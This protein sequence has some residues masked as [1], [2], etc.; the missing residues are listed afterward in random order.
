MLSVIDVYNFKNTWCKAWKIHSNGSIST[1]LA[2]RKLSFDMLKTIHAIQIRVY[3]VLLFE[4]HCP[5]SQNAIFVLLLQNHLAWL[6]LSI[7]HTIHE[8]KNFKEHIYILIWLF[9][10]YYIIVFLGTLCIKKPTDAIPKR[11]GAI[12][13]FH[14]IVEYELNFSQS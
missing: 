3:F 10:L 8:K 5:L 13:L 6:V 2:Y 11:M 7:Q 1:F 9:L 12:L 14:Q 4:R